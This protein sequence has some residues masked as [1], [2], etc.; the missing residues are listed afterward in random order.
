M[1]KRGNF[2]ELFA[3]LLAGELADDLA[4]GQSVPFADATAEEHGGDPAACCAVLVAEPPAEDCVA[5]FENHIEGVCRFMS[6]ERGVT[7]TDAEILSH[8]RLHRTRRGARSAAW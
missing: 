7:N 5:D 3:G 1:L 2:S 6:S 4:G 8:S